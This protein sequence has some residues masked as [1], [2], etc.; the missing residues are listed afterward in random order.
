MSK[1][2]LSSTGFRD[3]IFKLKPRSFHSFVKNIIPKVVDS[4][5]STNHIS[6]HFFRAMIRPSKIITVADLLNAILN[7]TPKE[8]MF[9][10]QE[11]KTIPFECR[12]KCKSK[13]E[14]STLYY[15][16]FYSDSIFIFK[17]NP[18]INN[19][20]V[21]HVVSER[22]GIEN[23][24]RFHLNNSTYQFH[25]DNFLE[26]KLSYKEL[27]AILIKLKKK[28]KVKY[29]ILNFVLTAILNAR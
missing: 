7:E 5:Q 4:C 13:K 19:K 17:L 14:N 28:G 27:T 12:V 11:W 22:T 29:S 16:I 24:V 1:T 2:A 15:G 25:L 10:S 9:K 20:K 18:N 8:R 3:Q 21:K 23:D 6:F 26:K